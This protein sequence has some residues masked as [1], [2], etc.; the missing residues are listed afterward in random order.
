MTR[1]YL[2]KKEKNGVRTPRTHDLS[3]IIPGTSPDDCS[4]GTYVNKNSAFIPVTQKCVVGVQSVNEYGSYCIV[5][6]KTKVPNGKK[7]KVLCYYLQ[8]Q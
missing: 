1:T 7:I 4:G 8:F 3:I 6:L 2:R 5:A